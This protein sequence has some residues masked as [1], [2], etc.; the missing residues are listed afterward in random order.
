MVIGERLRALAQQAPER[1]PLLETEE[2]TKN[3]LV[4][5][6]LQALG[7]DVFNPR[8]VVPEFT[9]DVGTKKG[10]KV[11]YAIKW[12]GKV[13][14]LVECKKAGCDLGRADRS[15]LYR[16]F[17]VTQTRI[18][19]LT[20]GSKYL[21]FSDLEDVN[22]MDKRPFM[23]FDLLAYREDLVEE[24]AKMSRSAFDL[25]GMLAAASDLKC[26]RDI[27]AALESELN[28]PSD[29]F[30]RFLFGRA[31]PNGRFAKTA[32]EQYTSLAPKVIRELL[33]DR[34]NER[35]S[36]ALASEE[37]TEQE[38]ARTGDLVPDAEHL[39]TVGKK[40][41]G[42]ETTEEEVRGF[43]IV[44]T[45]V[46]E[47]VDSSRIRWRDHKNF[48]NVLL[49]GSNRKP[50]AR[51][52]FDTKPLQLGLF[53]PMKT[54]TRHELSGVEDLARF[55]ESL[56]ESVRHYLEGASPAGRSTESSAKDDNAAPAVS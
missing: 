9:A 30:L 5:P 8:E 29:D 38:P 42:V 33:K 6:F 25:D 21:F 40:S 17:S 12:D 32:R 52:Y 53:D 2:A 47:V 27:R 48:F 50:L 14:I 55:G 31:N 41:D 7:Y 13:V 34:V 39:P 45:L 35:I 20:N 36:S 18:A 26:M 11:D 51:L 10:E 1:I 16:Y 43:T 4:M 22:K 24:L 44:R 54:E 3:A 49:D 19:V 15:Q 46:S 37:S 23:E 56:R 28:Q